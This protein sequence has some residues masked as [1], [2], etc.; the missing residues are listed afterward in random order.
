M[1]A[2][3]FQF[4]MIIKFILS[5][6]LETSGIKRQDDRYRTVR[7]LQADQ[8]IHLYLMSELV[9]ALVRMA[10][11]EV[12]TGALHRPNIHG[13]AHFCCSTKL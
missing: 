12:V 4:L 11:V 1:K 13:L 8:A 10:R 2:K 5:T 3:T 7:T 6:N 9:T